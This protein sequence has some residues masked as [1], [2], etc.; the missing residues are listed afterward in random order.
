MR[1]PSSPN[2]RNQNQASDV[3]NW[4]VAPSRRVTL[5]KIGGVLVVLT[6]LTIGAVVLRGGINIYINQ[7]HIRR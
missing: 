6:V 7:V 1:K 4:S 3:W 5:A 2:R